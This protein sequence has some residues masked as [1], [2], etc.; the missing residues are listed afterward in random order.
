MKGK[1]F[2]IALM[3]ALSLT[4]SLRVDR[5]YAAE[6]V[7]F[8][9]HFKL[10]P[11]YGLPAWAAIDQG[12]F[13]EL[14]LEVD[15]VPFRSAGTMMKAV[16]AKKI[17]MGTHGM[18]SAILASSRGVSEVIVADPKMKVDFFLWVLSGSKIKGARDLRGARIGVSRL[19]VGPHRLAQIAVKALGLEKDVKFIGLGGGRPAIAGLKAGSVEALVFTAFT[20]A[21]LKARGEVREVVRLNE[22]APEGPGHQIIFA[23]RDFISKNR[24]VVKKVIVAFLRGGQFIMKNKDWAIAKMQ[25]GT[26]SRYSQQAATA[27]YPLLRYG[28]DGRIERRKLAGALNYLVENGL[29]PK[30]KV[31]SLDSV[32]SKGLTD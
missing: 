31:P 26:L 28:G 4:L 29:I 25:E 10:N 5:G 27:A 32:Y 13:K 15:W 17:D 2:L 24:D 22:Y 1:I 14:G 3:V 23:R 9:T 12:Y 6:K 21:P 30:E 8:A 16:A 11:Y 7:R 18:E 19:G 20:M